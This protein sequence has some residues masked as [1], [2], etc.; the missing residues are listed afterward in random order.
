MGANPG[1]LSR[2]DK[3]RAAS[4]MRRIHCYYGCSDTVARCLVKDPKCQTAR[5]LAGMIVRMTAHGRSDKVIRREVMLRAKSMHP[6]KKYKIVYHRD[7]CTADPAKAK[8]V[9]ATFAEF[10]CPFCQIILPIL[11]KIV[12]RLGAKV[13]LCYKHFP[14]S[15]HGKTAVR[16]SH[17]A[18]AAARQGKFWPMH[19]ILYKNR[20]R[21]A[22]HFLEKYARGL[23]LNIS[24]WRAD[25]NSRSTRKLVALDKRAG[26]KLGVRGTP[27]LFINGKRYHGRKDRAELTDRIGEE[28]HLKAGGR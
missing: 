19:D 24:R 11:R 2:A 21:Q 14:T 10:Q 23:G 26:L 18:V 5:R 15:V 17:S 20:R 8:V 25:R 28:L 9:I 3:K 7:H 12:G 27:T 1:K 6:F 13:A 16:S 4:L 22:P